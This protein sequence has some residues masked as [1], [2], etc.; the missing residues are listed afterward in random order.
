MSVSFNTFYD[1]YFYLSVGHLNTLRDHALNRNFYIYPYI[2]YIY[3][4]FFF[5]FFKHLFILTTI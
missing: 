1:K 5:F 4:Q 2:F 3:I